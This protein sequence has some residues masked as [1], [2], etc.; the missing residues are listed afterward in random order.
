MEVHIR[1]FEMGDWED[2]AELFLLP[3]CQGGTLLLPCQSRDDIRRRLENPPDNMY[4]LVAVEA[5]SGKV[6]GMLSLHRHKGRRAHAAGIGMMVHDDYQN[7]GVGSRLMAAVI[8]LADNWLDL[9][10]LELT[11]YTDNEAAIRLYRKFG[12]EVEGTH[13]AYA[14]RDGAY[15]DT[16]AMARVRV[17][18]LEHRADSS[19]NRR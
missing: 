6:V 16:L 8:D 3:K 11:V 7:Q 19:C 12:F 10:R 4:R 2:V 18:G 13:R 5:D 14:F 17:D 1:A 15:V 9:R